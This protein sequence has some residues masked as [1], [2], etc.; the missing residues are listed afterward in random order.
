MDCSLHVLPLSLVDPI[1]QGRQM[2]PISGYD[3][4][5]KVGFGVFCIKCCVRHIL[6]NGPLR[7]VHGGAQR[8]APDRVQALA[9]TVVLLIG[10]FEI[11]F[12]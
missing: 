7:S 9:A 4:L 11:V 12:G 8:G 10:R 5:L 1:D 6:T 2:K 3:V